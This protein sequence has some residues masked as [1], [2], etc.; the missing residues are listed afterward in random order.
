MWAGYSSTRPPTPILAAQI[1]LSERLEDFMHVGFT[2]S[3]GEGS[4][5]HLVHHWQFKTFGYD[6]PSMYVVEE[7]DCFLCYE[8]DS[9]GESEGSSMSNK[10]IERKKKIGE[11][12]LGLGGLTAFVVSGLAAMIVVCVFLTKKKSS[13]RK[14]RKLQGQSCRF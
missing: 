13:V 14:N 7:G 8:G 9:T 1:D 4:S 5:V 12:A 11:M 3:N 6:S 10:D 2:A